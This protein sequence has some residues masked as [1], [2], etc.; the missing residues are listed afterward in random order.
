MK[1]N[2]IA[3]VRQVLS[4][5]DGLCHTLQRSGLLPFEVARFGFPC[6]VL[7]ADGGQFLRYLQGASDFS[8]PATTK[9]QD[10]VTQL[11]DQGAQDNS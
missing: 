7:P 6:W 11:G 2:R 9:A 3:G 5:K 10:E 8:L 1:I 4:T